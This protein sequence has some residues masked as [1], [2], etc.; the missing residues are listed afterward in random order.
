MLGKITVYSINLN[1]GNLQRDK[2][3]M[4][5]TAKEDNMTEVPLWYPLAA[6]LFFKAKNIGSTSS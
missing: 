3:L 1:Y 5:G 4:E 2:V 6:K